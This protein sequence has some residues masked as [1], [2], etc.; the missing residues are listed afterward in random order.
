MGRI[1][2]HAA[3]VERL[4]IDGKSADVPVVYVAAGEHVAEADD[5]GRAIRKVVRVAPGELVSVTLAPEP[6]KEPAVIVLGPP[7]PPP[8]A[9]PS[10]RPLPPAVPIVG[11][12]LT[13]AAGGLTL[14]S[15]LDTRSKRD[16][17]LEDRTQP[18]LDD[19]YASQT[20]TNVLIATTAGLGVVTA[21]LAGFFTEWSGAH[22]SERS[23]VASAP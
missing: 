16:A 21:V 7:P 19:A 20:R 4:R 14:A 22:A 8:V 1:E 9:P 6:K 3:G 2:P 12:V 17:F 10:R 11:L 5:Q 13:A 15:G 23:G 18:R